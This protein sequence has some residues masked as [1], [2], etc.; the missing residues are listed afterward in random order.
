MPRMKDD[1]IAEFLLEPHIGVLASLQGN[2][3][4][5]TVPVWWLHDSRRRSP[6]VTRCAIGMQIASAPRGAHLALHHPS[7]QRKYLSRPGVPI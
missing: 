7:Q 5:Y 6:C 1:T 3:L 4:P 2:G